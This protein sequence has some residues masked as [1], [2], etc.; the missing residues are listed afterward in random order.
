[1]AAIWTPSAASMAS[2]QSWWR[3]QTL[4]G[5]SRILDLES[6]S[7]SR[8]RLCPGVSLWRHVSGRTINGIRYALRLAAICKD[9]ANWE[10]R[11]GFEHRG[12]LKNEYGPGVAQSFATAR[13]ST[14]CP[15]VFVDSDGS[16]RLRLRGQRFA[17]RISGGISKSAIGSLNTMPF[18]TSA[19]SRARPQPV[20]GLP[21]AGA[22][23]CCCRAHMPGSGWLDLPCSEFC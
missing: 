8:Q 15:F 6:D 9:F 19:S 12:G 3:T 17:T 7:G 13:C 22:M 1:M 16:D 5:G 14:V 18:P 20:P 23:K 21:I 4:C 11:A 10:L 2:M